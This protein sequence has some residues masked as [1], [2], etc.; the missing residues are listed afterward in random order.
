LVPRHNVSRVWTVA[1]V[2]TACEFRIRK[3]DA[4]V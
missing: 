3:K 1:A 4:D 2:L